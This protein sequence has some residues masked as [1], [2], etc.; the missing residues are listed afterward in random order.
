MSAAQVVCRLASRI[1]WTGM[2]LQTRLRRRA[3]VGLAGALGVSAAV[4]ALVYQSRPHTFDSL[5]PPL[6]VARVAILNVNDLK[7]RSQLASYQA[8]ATRMREHG[9]IE[10]HNLVVERRTTGGRSTRNELAAELLRL[11]VDV[12]VSGSTPVLLGAKN[13]GASMPLV[14]T[15]VSDPVATGLVD[16]LARPGGTVT[17]LTL[18]SP[19]LSQKR[20]QLL[21][22]V[23]PR[24]SRVGF[25][26]AECRLC[27]VH[28]RASSRN[29]GDRSAHRRTG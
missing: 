15:T 8:F 18:F 1:G 28:R 23:V 11:P 13:L 7:H 12:L 5:H 25:Q 17:G 3:F 22:Q 29:S 4:G 26:R 27:S 24:L 21:A 20:L 19:E 9:W 14:M 2:Q 10:G 6:R 16:S